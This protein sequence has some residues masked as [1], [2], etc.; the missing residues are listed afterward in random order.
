MTVVV[1]LD[2]STQT[3]VIISNKLLTIRTGTTQNNGS[4][5]LSIALIDPGGSNIKW[6]EHASLGRY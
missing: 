4:S 3:G 2:V 5:L 6:I 1:E